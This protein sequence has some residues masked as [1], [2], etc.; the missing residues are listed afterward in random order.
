M[1]GNVTKW[2]SVADIEELLG[3]DAVKRLIEGI[4]TKKR[5]KTYEVD[6]INHR[7]VRVKVDAISETLAREQA[8]RIVI[9]AM[10][11]GETP[12]AAIASSD[13]IKTRIVKKAEPV[14]PTITMDKT[15]VEGGALRVQARKK[16]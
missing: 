9:D 16:K 14:A 15:L 11:E 13:W 8:E 1:G 10:S 12:Q 3:K 2:L 7:L 4:S 6:V 5:S